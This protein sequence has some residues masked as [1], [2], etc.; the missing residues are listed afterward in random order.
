[1]AT[2]Y[3]RI[4][5]QPRTSEAPV[6]KCSFLFTVDFALYLFTPVRFLLLLA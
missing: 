5:R 3:N 2:A 1:M 6:A 4:G